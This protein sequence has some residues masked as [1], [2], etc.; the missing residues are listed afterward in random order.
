MSIYRASQPPRLL[1]AF[2]SSA[3]LALEPYQRVCIGQGHGR[4]PLED[5]LEK[6]PI[7]YHRV[8]GQAFAGMFHLACYRDLS[9]RT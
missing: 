8:V 1:R 7:V 5:H 4:P 9:C 6:L 2:R 3:R